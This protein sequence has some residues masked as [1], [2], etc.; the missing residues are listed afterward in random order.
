MKGLIKKDLLNLSS[1]KTSLLITIIFCS[2]AIAGTENASIA[3]MIICAII[4]MISLSTFNYDE[5]SKSEKYILSLPVNRKELVISKYIIA[6]SSAIIGA[7]IGVLLTILIVNIM[8]SVRPNNLIDLDY[9]NLFI[10]SLSGLFGI[11]LIQAIQIP[12]IYKWGA[13]KGRIQMFILIFFMV[14]IIVGASF[15]ITKL[16]L[17]LDIQK[18]NNFLETFGA[19]ILT[20]LI[21]IMYTISYKISYKIFIKKDY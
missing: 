21:I 14:L 3:P 20:L 5:V 16:G 19:Y 15:L 8:N 6:I 13:E 17:N 11:A 9:D 7:I 1:Y 18:I 10:T 4:G 2:I 12:S